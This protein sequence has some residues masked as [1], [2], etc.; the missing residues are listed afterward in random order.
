MRMLSLAAFAI[1]ALVIGAY[2]EDAMILVI[3]IAPAAGAV[4]SRR[5]VAEHFVL[6]FCGALGLTALSLA[7]QIAL[8]S[9]WVTPTPDQQSTFQSVNFAWKVGAATIIGLLGG[10]AT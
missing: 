7:V 10:K 2:D 5:S 8:A 6:I 1:L 9:H 4:A 3:G